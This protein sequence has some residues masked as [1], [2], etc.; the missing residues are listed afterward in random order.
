MPQI[1]VTV[2]DPLYLQAQLYDEEDSL[3]LYIFAE[4][5]KTDGTLLTTIEL[6]HTSKGIFV[7]ETYTMPNEVVLFV[8]YYVFGDHPSPMNP[9]LIPKTDDY[10]IIEER[11]V[12]RLDAVITV[13]GEPI[14]GEIGE[15]TIIEGSV[16]EV[17]E[18][19]GEVLDFEEIAGTIQVIET[20]EG[21]IIYE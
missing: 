11:Y 1:E 12:R 4:V 3:P 15:I 7:D 6:F 10:G 8:K 2:G 5:Y 21:E 9:S 18:I 14:I 13:I 16:G 17:T 19:T 20:I